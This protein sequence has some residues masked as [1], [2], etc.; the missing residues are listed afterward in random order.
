MEQFPFCVHSPPEGDEHQS[1]Q[2]EEQFVPAEVYLGQPF[3]PR[4]YNTVST[5]LCVRIKTGVVDGFLY[6]W[7]EI[8]AITV[9][10]TFCF[11]TTAFVK[12]CRKEYGS[13]IPIL[14]STW[15]AFGLC[16][17]FNL[18]YILSVSGLYARLQTDSRFIL[19]GFGRLSGHG[20]FVLFNMQQRW[21]V[22]ELLRGLGGKVWLPGREWR[23]N[24]APLS[25][26][27]LPRLL[28][29]QKGWQRSLFVSME[30][31]RHILS[32][33]GEC[34]THSC[35]KT[36]WFR[37]LLRWGGSLGS[38]AKWKWKKNYFWL[39]SAADIIL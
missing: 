32:L 34:V 14:L 9:L 27:E 37:R 25:W 36:D 26:L 35:L 13:D 2:K 8:K 22:P 3:A 18:R 11:C 24:G 10:L 17:W 30:L 16:D 7:V 20:T 38:R 33:R 28:P 5:P 15:L 21:A 19:P 4:E 6:S 29:A 39:V 31:Y 12:P 23:G 1:L